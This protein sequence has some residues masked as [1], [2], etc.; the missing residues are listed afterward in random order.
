MATNEL[1]KRITLSNKIIVDET[2]VK[3]VEAIIT[4]SENGETQLQLNG[5]YQDID[6]YVLNQNEV[7]QKESE[8]KKQAIQEY[9]KIKDE[10]N[11]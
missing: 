10:L 3:M 6:K 1:S 9:Q 5:W 4:K 2:I 11:I 8:F 7:D